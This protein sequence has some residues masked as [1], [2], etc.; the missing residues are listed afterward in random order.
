MAKRGPKKQAGF[1]ESNGRL[2]RGSQSERLD[3]ISRREQEAI[4]SVVLCQPHRRGRLNAMS[5]TRLVDAV[6][7]FCRDHRLHGCILD[8]AC[9]YLAAERRWMAGYGAPKGFEQHSGGGGA[10]PTAE[11]MSN[12]L[13]KIKSVE[14]GVREKYGDKGFLIIRRLVIEDAEL[15]TENHRLVIACLCEIA[16]ALDFM[17]SNP[18]PFC[19]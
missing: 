16:V 4:M 12:W 13:A 14:R 1:R 3:E 11:Q 18:H 10:G 5:D 6:G 17:N 9:E 19:G 8:A 2:H 15:T 7:R